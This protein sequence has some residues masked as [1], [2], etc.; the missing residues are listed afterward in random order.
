MSNRGARLVEAMKIRGLQKQH[1]LAYALGVNESTVTRW[2][3]DGP[4]SLESAVALCGALD[5]SLDWFL[6]GYGSMDRQRASPGAG[7]ESDDPLW[8]SFHKA[9]AAMSAQSKALL[10]AFIDSMMQP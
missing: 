10:I 9:A 2:K 8:A 7:A 5:I 1:A 6:A 3:N 4:M